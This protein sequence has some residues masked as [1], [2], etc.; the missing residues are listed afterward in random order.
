MSYTPPQE[1]VQGAFDDLI[2]A[3]LTPI[4]QLVA[5]YS[6]EVCQAITEEF[7]GGTASIVDNNFDCSTGSNT[8]GLASI[9]TK[10]YARYRAGQGVTALF[11][12]LFSSPQPNS[13]LL[14]GLLATE[15]GLAVGYIGET[16]GFIRYYGG[17]QEAQKLTVTTPAGG[18]ETATV[19]VDGTGY[20]VNLTSGTTAHNS[21][22]IA[23]QLSSAV[24]G[25]TFAANNSFVFALANTAAA[26][27]AFAFSSSS[28]VA[29]WTQLNSGVAVTTSIV[30]IA[31]WNGEDTSWIDP[32]KGNVFKISYPYLGY[33]DTL[34]YV[35][36]PAT[37]RFAL[38]HR[39]HYTNL[40]TTTSM[41]SPTLRGGWYAENYGNTTPVWI[42]G[43]SCGIFI[44][45]KAIHTGPRRGFVTEQLAVGTTLTNVL[46]IRS[47]SIFAGKTNRI[48]LLPLILSASTS[49][50]KGAFF[51]VF[52]NPTFAT[53]PNFTFID[54]ATSI[55]EVAT[56]AVGVTG[57]AIFGVV[58]GQLQPSILTLN[59]E[60][61]E[62]TIAPGDTICIAARVPSGAAADMYASLTWQEDV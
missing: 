54:E 49:G 30:P 53:E 33:G 23:T 50:S 35:K 58:A 26:A 3:E 45:G 19:T 22:E 60:D 13:K 29:A 57:V 8:Q 11:T 48:E 21:I 51:E 39:L 2:T 10:R 14:A 31:E 56:D 12:A 24:P 62:L 42:R 34:L 5:D 7:N 36:S 38:A 41:L 17:V 37:G 15:N 44:E 20:S 46:A 1:L 43:G 28:A 9:E 4:A 52:F 18:A 40:N 55:A 59:E 47:R 61:S 6:L 27:G 25:Y 32:T 16:F